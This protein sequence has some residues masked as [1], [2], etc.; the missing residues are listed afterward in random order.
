M[1]GLEHER[2]RKLTLDVNDDE[3]VHEIV[4]TVVDEEG[5]ID[6]LVNNAGVL[7]VGTKII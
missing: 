6:V 2:V 4:R 1:T 5:R 7:C 3:N